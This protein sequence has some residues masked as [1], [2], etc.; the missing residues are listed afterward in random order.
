MIDEYSEVFIDLSKEN[1]MIG[2]FHI[3]MQI[4]NLLQFPWQLIQSIINYKFSVLN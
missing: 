4:I 1:C 2:E 3:F